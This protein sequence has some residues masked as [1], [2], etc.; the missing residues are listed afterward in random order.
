MRLPNPAILR[1]GAILADESRMARSGRSGLAFRL[2]LCPTVGQRGRMAT[3]PIAF[4]LLG[5]ILAV[6]AN[7]IASRANKTKQE[8]LAQ[9]KAGAE[10]A[11]FEERRSLEAYP[12]RTG[13]LRAFG[14]FWVVC[15]AA[16]LFF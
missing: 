4:I 15:G 11:F 14:I 7:P 1:N 2:E 5:T 9:L 16:I 10:E 12:A 13:W 8:R 3:K 6:F